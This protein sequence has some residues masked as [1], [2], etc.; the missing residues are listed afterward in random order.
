MMLV[1]SC[2]FLLSFPSDI[3]MMNFMQDDDDVDDMKHDMSVKYDVDDDDDRDE[4]LIPH[5]P[6]SWE[7]MELQSELRDL[8]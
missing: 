8:R 2:L 1:L 6:D 3:D 4:S 5:D 7:K